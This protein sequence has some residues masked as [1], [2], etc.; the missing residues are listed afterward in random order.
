MIGRAR[1]AWRCGLHRLACIIRGLVRGLGRLLT[2]L[3]C[4]R[5]VVRQ[6]EQVTTVPAEGAVLCPDLV[7]PWCVPGVKDGTRSTSVS[8]P[9]LV[10]CRETTQRSRRVTL[11]KILSVFAYTLHLSSSKKS[12]LC[13]V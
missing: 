11:V 2:L 10:A 4:T 3:L 12:L 13:E 6:Q 7:G 5:L 1:L 9:H 8:Q